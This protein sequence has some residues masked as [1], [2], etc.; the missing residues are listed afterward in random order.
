MK[1]RYLLFGFIIVGLLLRAYQ[2]QN[3]LF[4]D[5]DEGIYAELAAESISKN[6]YVMT[7]F[8]GE[9]WIDKPPIGSI[10]MSIGFL[11][12]PENKELGSRLMMVLV[13]SCMLILLYQLSRKIHSYFFS[14]SIGRLPEWQQELVYF[15]PVFVTALT[16][17]FHERSIHLNTDTLL[18]TS[19]L[20][21]FVYH[22]SFYGRL[23]FVGFGTWAKS[24]L[25][26]Y[27]MLFDVFPFM[28]SKQKAQ[29][30]GRYVII[31][32]VAC[33]WHIFNYLTYGQSFLKAH[34]QDQLLKRVA[35]P[36][37]LHFG[38]RM[39]YPEFLIKELSIILIIIG[40]AYLLIT[41]DIVKKIQRESGSSIVRKF[42][43]YI[44][45]PEFYLYALLFSAIPFFGFLIFAKSKIW[46]Y[47]MMV[48][49][50]FALTVPYAL[51]RIQKDALR[52]IMLAGIILFFLYKFIPATYA[53]RPVTDVPEKLRVAQCVDL[54]PGDK[55][56][57]VV[58]DQ[59]RRNRNVVEAAQLQTNSS[60]IYGGSPAFIYYA[61][62]KVNH[63]YKMEELPQ[64]LTALVVISKDDL[65][66]QEFA[67]VATLLEKNYNRESR[68]YFGEWAVYSLKK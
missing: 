50:L 15:S 9:P 60:F 6:A 3:A 54:L 33:A 37:E 27:P 39:Y 2:Y 59:E 12:M 11:L 14:E 49:P 65:E 24:I 25:G 57:F 55:V 66:R 1:L 64:G 4:T 19:W 45:T 48:I 17:L 22:Q 46:W 16:P 51:M 62:K 35:V 7:Q 36:I 38:G 34:F 18:A 29:E 43:S 31:I 56:T 44:Q 67:Q 23:F 53:L 20:G 52:N 30:I 28:G 26:F 41:Y 10:V 21:Y 61:N 68:C 8:N 13:A 58:N 42:I 40:V 32:V 47:I 63:I 5:W